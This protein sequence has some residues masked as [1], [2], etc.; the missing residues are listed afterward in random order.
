MIYNT[1]QNEVI[2]V[3]RIGLNVQILR[4]SRDLNNVRFLVKYVK[5]VNNKSLVAN[6]GS[7]TDALS[8]AQSC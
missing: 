2:E 8:F 5:T 3:K 7:Y 4:D 6:C 1:T